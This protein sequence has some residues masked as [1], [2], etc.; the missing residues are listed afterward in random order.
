MALCYAGTLWKEGAMLIE[1]TLP[2]SPP[3]QPLEYTI[4]QGAGHRY[5]LRFESLYSIEAYLGYKS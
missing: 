2:T 5:M 3:P 4:L 1:H